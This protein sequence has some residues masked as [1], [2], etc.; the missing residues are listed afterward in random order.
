MLALLRA[1]N[2]KKKTI[3]VKE[4]EFDNNQERMLQAKTFGH[5]VGHS[6]FI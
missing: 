6:W 3:R 4:I 1:V 5:N 2:H